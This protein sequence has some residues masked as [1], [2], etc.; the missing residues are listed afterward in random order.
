MT[1]HNVEFCGVSKSFGAIRA[2]RDFTLG[3]PRGQFVTLLGASGSGKSTTL[4]MLAG[5][6]APDAGTIR[7]NGADVTQVPAHRRDIGLVYQHY[8]LFPHMTVG[9]N[10]AFPL[11][12][13][14]LGRSEIGARVEAALSVVQL[15][16][17]ADRRPSQLSGGQQ[18]R[19]ALAR[20]LVFEPSILLMDEP[21]GALDKKLREEMQIEIQRIQKDSHITTIYVTHDQEEAMSMSDVIVVMRRGRIEQ[22]GAPDEVYERPK[23]AFV[24][25]FVGSANILHGT[26]ADGPAPAFRSDAGVEIAVGPHPGV[27]GAGRL[28]LIIRPER[29]ALHPGAS[30]AG[31]LPAVVRTVVYGGSTVRYLVGL[32]ESAT[33]TVAQ[34]NVGT[35]ALREHDPV[36]LDW[37]DE[38]VLLVP[39][40]D[41]ED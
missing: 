20:A 28:S 12:M 17:F 30:A 38:D 24:A 39:Y 16:G 31:R 9:Q 1:D 15:Q 4:M 36:T 40:E 25:E 26:L 18:Q 7:I 35:P 6:L 13:R 5:F 22:V 33:F 10:V 11:E 29:I 14:G 2:V 37:R 23:N 3:V 8:A 41:R 27:D 19:V 32:G 21:L 34:T